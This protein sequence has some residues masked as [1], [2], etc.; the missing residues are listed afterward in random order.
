M[1]SVIFHLYSNFHSATLPATTKFAEWWRVLANTTRYTVIV[2]AD[3][4]VIACIVKHVTLATSTD[5]CQH[6]QFLKTNCIW[7]LGALFDQL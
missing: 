7:N 1:V 6:K 2:N 5:V 3:W 4:T